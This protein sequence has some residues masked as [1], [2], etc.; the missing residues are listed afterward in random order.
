MRFNDGQRRRLAAKAKGLGRR[1][2]A[3]IATIVT[4]E[5]LFAGVQL[6]FIPPPQSDLRRFGALLTTG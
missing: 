3:E 6:G 2:L 1:L 4:P 5:T